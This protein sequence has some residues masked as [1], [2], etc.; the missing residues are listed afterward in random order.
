MIVA[1]GPAEA[2]NIAREQSPLHL[3]ITD[4]VMPGL[5]GREL[6]QQVS[7]G[8][9]DLRVLFISGYAE[10]ALSR[11]GVLDP[12]VDLLLKPFTAASLLAVVRGVLKSAV[13]LLEWMVA[14][15]CG[16]PSPPT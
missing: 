10:N 1:R 14:A 16:S 2:L 12:G 9:Q 4:V 13:S 3:L 5:G 6:A 11:E 15:S 7:Q 8:Q